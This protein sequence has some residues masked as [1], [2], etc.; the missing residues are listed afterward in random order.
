M[1]TEFTLAVKSAILLPNKAKEP[2]EQLIKEIGFENLNNSTQR[3]LPKIFKNLE[4]E[5]NISAY[6]KLKGAYKYNWTKNNRLLFSF[7]PILKALNEQSIDYRIL[8]GAALNLL[9]DNV[10]HRTMGDIDLL[11]GAADLIRISDIF[12]ENDF[13]KKYDTKCINAE[14]VEFDTEI[15]FLTP[16][17]FE[18]DVHLVEKTYPQLLYRKIMKAKPNFTQFQDQNVKLPNFELALIHAVYHGNKSVSETD[19]IQTYLD[20]DQLMNLIEVKNLYKIAK[21][22]N[23]SSVINSSLNE[24]NFLRNEKPVTAV[25]GTKLTLFT[26]SYYLW[27]LKNKFLNSSD[28]FTI[29]TARAMSKKEIR[30]VQKNFEGRKILYKLWL[31]IGKP[32]PFERIVFVV[33][34]G[35]LKNPKQYPVLGESFIGFEKANQNWFKTNLT[36]FESHDWRFKIRVPK[37]SKIATIEMIAEEFKNW[38]WLIFINGKFFGTTTQ[39]HHGTY[40]IRYP[41]PTQNL[42]ISLRSPSHVCELCEHGISDLFVRVHT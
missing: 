23:F 20:C 42:E 32:R 19:L 26:P 5:T 27:V 21:E 37:E 7:L 35:F 22:L 39:I 13:Q 38:N 28:F 40:V 31:R 2:W 24:L 18:V 29:K 30:A 11:I 8:K 16:E 14:R 25:K 6:E 17:K 10:G 33:F 3:V 15:C 9:S 41:F 12:E 36:A 4:S 1:E 34:G